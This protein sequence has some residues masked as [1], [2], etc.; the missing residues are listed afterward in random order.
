MMR[1][2]ML[3][4]TLGLAVLA[5]GCAMRGS[6]GA[7]APIDRSNEFLTWFEG[8]WIAQEPV[9]KGAV[10]EL[11]IAR[12]P[13]FGQAFYVEEIREGATRQWV[14]MLTKDE[15]RYMAHTWRITR[16]AEFLGAWRER[17]KLADMSMYYV[18]AVEDCDMVFEWKGDRFAG[19]TAGG[20]CAGIGEDDA[21]I[22]MSQMEFADGM[23]RYRVQA[24]GEDG[25]R[26]WGS[27]EWLELKKSQ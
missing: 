18:R 8:D 26:V 12:L 6:T 9:E 14:A 4:V 10:R 1:R 27:G 20:G 7:V 23:M 25:R 5:A 22:V 16:P 3:A 15:A 19:A 17:A 24:F 13:E 2:A 21:Q 11:H